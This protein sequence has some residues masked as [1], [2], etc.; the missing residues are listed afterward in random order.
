MFQNILFVEGNHDWL[1]QLN[2][3]VM[4]QLCE[5][6]GITLLRDSSV[7][8][9][10]IN[11]YGSPWNIEFWNWAWNLSAGAQMKK[12][13]DLIPDNTHVLITHS[14]PLGILDSVIQLN[15][16]SEHVEVH[17]GC[18]ELYKKVQNLTNLR[19]HIYGHIHFSSGQMKIGDTYFVNASICTEE[20][21]ATNKPITIEI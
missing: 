9:D 15:N 14:P 13:W 8:I 4:Q 1:G 17:L 7:T 2:P 11:F 21:R 3:I 19:A 12:K 10:G 20:Y 16:R 18:E 5:D 6:N